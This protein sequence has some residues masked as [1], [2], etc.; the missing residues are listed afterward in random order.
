[1]EFDPTMGLDQIIVG[2]SSHSGFMDEDLFQ[3]FMIWDDQSGLRLWVAVCLVGVAFIASD[4]CCN[5]NYEDLD[6]QDHPCESSCGFTFCVLSLPQ[7]HPMHNI[8]YHV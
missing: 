2:Y 1:M 3:D 5:L 7:F 6:Y 4:H 8:S